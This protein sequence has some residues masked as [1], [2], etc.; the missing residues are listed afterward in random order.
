MLLNQLARAVHTGKLRL[1]ERDRGLLR[2]AIEV[3]RGVEKAVAEVT[4]AARRR[5]T[6]ARRDLAASV[7]AG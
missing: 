5:G 4:G 6:R 3:S 7:R 2:E 1:T